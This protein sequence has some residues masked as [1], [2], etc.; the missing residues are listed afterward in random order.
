MPSRQT[1]CGQDAGPSTVGLALVTLGPWTS[2][3]KLQTQVILTSIWPGMTKDPLE[4]AHFVQHCFGLDP[5][6][7]LSS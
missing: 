1:A 5:N 6:P 2:V 3:A 7:C 4:N